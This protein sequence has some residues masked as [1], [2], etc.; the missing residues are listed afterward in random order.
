MFKNQ[1]HSV[2]LLPRKKLILEL[3][4]RMDLPFFFCSCCISLKWN[5]QIA[6][7]TFTFTSK[8]VMSVYSVHGHHPPGITVITQQNW[9]HGVKTGRLF[10]FIFSSRISGIP[11]YSAF[12]TKCRVKQVH[13]PSPVGS[14]IPGVQGWDQQKASVRLLVV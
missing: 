6:T 14:V 9:E 10:Q 2:A 3:D 5:S 1:A 12:E 4:G 8:C 11:G 7:L 13:R